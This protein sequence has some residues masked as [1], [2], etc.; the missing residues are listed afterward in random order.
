MFKSL[1][2]LFSAFFSPF[3]LAQGF[4]GGDEYEIVQL[5]GNVNI[6]CLDSSGQ[7][8]AFYF[9]RQDV[10]SPGPFQ[11]FIH[12]QSLL[13]DEVVITSQ[14]ADGS[15]R[16]Q[17]RRFDARSGLSRNFN[18]LVWTLFQRPLLLEGSNALTY[19]LRNRG[20]VVDYGQFDVEVR[21]DPQGRTCQSRTIFSSDSS[22]C[23]NQA[24]A[25]DRYFAL[26]SNCRY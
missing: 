1:L 9:C 8:T 18:L 12:P 7:S 21:R 17:T 10:V 20:A 15:V 26:S 14:R 13:A 4:V 16:E 11:P 22:M 6:V 25:C 19:E 3:L 24:Q 2:V 23:R 5:Q